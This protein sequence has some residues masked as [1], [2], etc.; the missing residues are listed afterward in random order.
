MSR[1]TLRS[2]VDAD[3]FLRLAVPV[4][5]AEADHAMQVTIES[6]TNEEIVSSD[7]VHWLD[8]IAGQWQGDFERLPVVDFEQRDS[9]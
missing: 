2:R 9:L 5:A 8:T 3:G 6:V 1:I 7:Y 4:G